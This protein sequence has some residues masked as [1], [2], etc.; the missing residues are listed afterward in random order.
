MDIKT[1]SLEWAPYEAQ[2]KKKIMKAILIGNKTVTVHWYSDDV[3]LQCFN[4][5]HVVTGSKQTNQSINWTIAQV[6]Q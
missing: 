5:Q 1:L 6:I 4:P 3:I 2:D